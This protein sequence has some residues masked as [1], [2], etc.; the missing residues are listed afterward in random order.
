MRIELG[1]VSIENYNQLAKFEE[2]YSTKR[3]AGSQS[4]DVTT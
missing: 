3:A 1:C 2:Q 4:Y